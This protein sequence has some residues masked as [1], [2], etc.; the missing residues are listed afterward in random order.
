M[1]IGR[2]MIEKRE[3]GVVNGLVRDHMV[4]IQKQDDFSVHLLH[5]VEERG[6]DGRERRS[7]WRVQHRPRR[8]AKCGQTGPYGGNDRE[9]E[10]DRIIVWLVKGEPGTSWFGSP[11]LCTQLLPPA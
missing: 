5:L 4:V 6:Q 1:H 7:L 3:Q 10:A 11:P 2:R 8:F 9:P